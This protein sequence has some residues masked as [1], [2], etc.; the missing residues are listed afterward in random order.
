MNFKTLGLMTGTV[1]FS[2]GCWSN[3]PTS[4]GSGYRPD[5]NSGMTMATSPKR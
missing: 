3:M 4:T 5:A 2:A 1:V